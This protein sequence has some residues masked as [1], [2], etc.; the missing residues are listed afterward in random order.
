MTTTTTTASTAAIANGTSPIPF[1]FQ[2][3]SAAEVGVLRNGIA[4]LLN[5]VDFTVTLN[6]DG[7]GTVVPAASWATDPIIVYSN[8][9]FQQPDNFTRFG[10]LYPDQLNPPLDRLAR[11]VIALKAMLN[12]TILVPFGEVVNAVLVDAASRA[13]K[14]LGFDVDGQPV[15]MDPPAGPPGANVMA[16]GLFAALSAISVPGGTTLIQTSGHTEQGKAYATYVEDTSLNDGD[17]AAFPATIGKTANG[18]YFRL[19]RDQIW[20]LEHFGTITGGNVGDAAA[21]FAALEAL[22][23]YDSRFAR[24]GVG[25][26]TAGHS[27]QWGDNDIHIGAHTLDLSDVEIRFLCE[28]GGGPAAGISVIRTSA[29]TAVRIQNADTTGATGTRA[30]TLATGSGSMID[31]LTA[32]SDYVNGNAESEAH[33]FHL[34]GKGALVN[35]AAFNFAGDGFNLQGDSQDPTRLG[36]VNNAMLVNCFAQSCRNGY[37]WSGADANT[38][39]IVNCQGVINRRWSFLNLSFLGSKLDNCSAE[40]NGLTPGTTPTISTY[41]G[42]RYCA[43][44]GGTWSNAPSGTTADTADW[45]YMG[46]GGVNAPLNINTWSALTTYRDGGGYRSDGGGNAENV[47]ISCYH[48]GGQGLSQIDPPALVIGGQLRRYLKGVAALAHVTSLGNATMEITGGL[49]VDGP[50]TATGPNIEI[51]QEA[52]T[53]AVDFFANWRTTN[54][55]VGHTAWRWDAGGGVWVNMGSANFTN[56]TLYLDAPFGRVDRY[57]G[58]SVGQVVP[59]GYALVEVA[60]SAAATPAAGLQTLFI[61]TADHKLKRKD[62]SGTVVIV[63]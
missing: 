38:I 53:P 37:A 54:F 24:S 49:R 41:S 59:G 22:K 9:S 51:G 20:R 34:R 6:G 61:D 55:T 19:G 29:T 26:G 33:G 31:G 63:N 17:V 27:I 43:R 11:A 1:D 13:G 28:N 50:L 10:A 52:G 30:I 32:V 45:Y 62:S 21:N 36:N 8:P 15:A 5:G 60:A 46:A 48:E 7:T 14:V 3:I 23:A 25:Y 4:T 56:G 39:L 18:R 2:A 57:N 16:I 44:K 58:T 40:N 42:N 35:C 12:R 47:F